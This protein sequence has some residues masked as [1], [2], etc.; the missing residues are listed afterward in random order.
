TVLVGYDVLRQAQR[1][2]GRTDPQHAPRVRVVPAGEVQAAIGTNCKP[3]DHA[4]LRVCGGTTLAT[5]EVQRTIGSIL[6]G[7]GVDDAVGR[8]APHPRRGSRR[9]V[10]V[11]ERD[12]Q[13]PVGCDGDVL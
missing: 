12:V 7:E 3:G 9:G 2:H 1:R 6:A 13:R 10:D 5:V 4:E 11:A 8:H